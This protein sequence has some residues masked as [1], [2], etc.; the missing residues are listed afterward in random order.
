VRATLKAGW[1]VVLIALLG[2]CD[3]YSSAPQRIKADNRIFFACSGYVRVSE[4]EVK[5]RSRYEIEFVDASGATKIISNIKKIELAAIPS[6]VSVPMPSPLPDPINGKDDDGLP[7]KE[8][9]TYTWPDGASAK[10]A[11]G[12]WVPIKERNPVCDSK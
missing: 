5:G 1:S 7:F 11:G 9:W 4:G 8:G 2:G 6:T 3:D 12:R 10:L